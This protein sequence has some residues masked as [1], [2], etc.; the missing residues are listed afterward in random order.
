MAC[1]GLHIS[2]EMLFTADPRR[3]GFSSWNAY[4]VVGIVTWTGL[5]VGLPA[6]GVGDV[7]DT[8]SDAVWAKPVTTSVTG[9][10][11]ADGVMLIR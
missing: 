6:V 9:C 2:R 11:P 7:R 3:S 1:P 4:E 10:W 5:R 8:V